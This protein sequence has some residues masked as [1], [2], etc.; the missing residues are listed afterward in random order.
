MRIVAARPSLDH[1]YKSPAELRTGGLE[2]LGEA[3]GIL[4]QK[5]ADDELGAYRQFVLALA[6]RVASA[7]RE[8]GVEISDAERAALDEIEVAVKEPR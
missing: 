6:E 8:D 2:K 3:I 7:H 1:G 4:E 5:A